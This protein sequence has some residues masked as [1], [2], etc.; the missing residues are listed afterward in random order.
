M[1][2]FRAFF[3]IEGRDD[4]ERGVYFE[5]KNTD[6]ADDIIRNGVADIYNCKAKDVEFYNL[7]SEFENPEGVNDKVVGWEAG[8]PIA[9]DDDPLIL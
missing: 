7:V 1:I 8:K 2:K 5:A 6:D 3:Y 9:W 4:S